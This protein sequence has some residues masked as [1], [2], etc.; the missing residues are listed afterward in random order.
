MKKA[1]LKKIIAMVL[2]IAMIACLCAG[3]SSQ[4]GGETK[5]PEQSKEPDKVWSVATETDKV[6]YEDLVAKL[7]ELKPEDIPEGLRIGVVLSEPTNEFWTNIGKGI[8]QAAKRYGVEVD[9]Q[10]CSSADDITGQVA[11]GE[12]VVA[13]DYDIYIMTSLA[14]DTMSSVV[15]LAHNKGK[16]VVNAISQVISN[17]DCYFG[18]DQYL[19]GQTAGEYV[20]DKLGGQGKVA[21]VMGAV[22]TEVNTQ[23]TKGFEDACK[24]GGLEVVAELAAEW[25]VE[26]AMNMAAD[27]LTTD[28]DI[29]AFFCVNDNMAI[30]VAEA[31][32]NKGLQ[33]ECIVIGVDGISATYESM[34]AGGQTATVDSFG[35]ESGERCLEMAIRLLMGQD[36]NRCVIGPVVVV[37]NDNRAEYGH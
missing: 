30:S 4:Q 2:T 18:Y 3:C 21:V 36:V 15:D 29:K 5:E 11:I 32:N 16:L 7:G 26:T 12:S 22:G 31:V 6:S 23:R 20:V 8:E 35:V 28:P 10:Y 13:Q 9:V 17:A 25:D 34:A 24:A 19:M 1:N 37:D 14:D 27:A 33:G